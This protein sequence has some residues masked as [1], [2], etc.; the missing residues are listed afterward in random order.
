VLPMNTTRNRYPTKLKAENFIREDK[1]SF[2][3]FRIG[4]R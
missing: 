1:N 2:M 3:S 4:N